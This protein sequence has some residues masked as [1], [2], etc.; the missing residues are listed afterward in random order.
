[1][2]ICST[3]FITSQ[4]TLLT[5][6]SQ[7]ATSN[8]DLEAGSAQEVYSLDAL[9][10]N[11]ARHLFGPFRR[12]GLEDLG[13]TILFLMPTNEERMRKLTIPEIPTSRSFM[14]EARN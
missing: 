9:I 3:G 5:V 10:V 14:V 6:E 1:M 8:E 2:L 4:L 12:T 11:Q 13:Y 7:L